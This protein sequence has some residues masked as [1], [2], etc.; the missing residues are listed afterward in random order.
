MVFII[1]LIDKQMNY[2][3]QEIIDQFL[4]KRN[5]PPV[6]KIIDRIDVTSTRELV[7]YS[8][9][10]GY[11]STIL[12]DKGLLNYKVLNYFGSINPLSKA[13]NFAFE[14]GDFYTRSLG[15]LEKNV[16]HLIWGIIYHPSVSDILYNNMDIVEHYKKDGLHI[17][18]YTSDEYIQPSKLT[19]LDENDTIIE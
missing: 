9:N 19:F 10:S 1:Y 15:S 3:E 8:Q 5:L 14:R 11:V 13:Q 2:S 18:Y 4:Q 17:F 6:E 7:V 12:L 16:E